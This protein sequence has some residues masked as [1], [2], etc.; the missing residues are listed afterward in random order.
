MS[1][2]NIE[3]VRATLDALNRGD[4]DAAFKEMAPDFEYD[5]SR[6]MGFQ[7]GVHTVD[8]ARRMWE[9]FASAWESSRVEA[10]EFIEAAGLSE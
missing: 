3:M 5:F 6:S 4:S 7:R 9:E 8:E 2:E 10:D 1:Q